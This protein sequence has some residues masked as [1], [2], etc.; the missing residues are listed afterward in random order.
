MRQG[1]LSISYW[2]NTRDDLPCTKEKLAKPTVYH[3]M[4]KLGA[5]GKYVISD[6]D[7]LEQVCHLQPETR[8]PVRL[9]DELKKNHLL[10]LGVDYSDWL[11]RI[12][13]RTAKGR[14]LSLSAKQGIFRDPGRQQDSSGR[15]PGLVP[16]SFQQPHAGLPDRRGR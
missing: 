4:G 13:L 11:V 14:N 2:H 9:F 6:E 7:L 10:M 15:R 5:T 3:L 1:A 12:F 8:R 16:G